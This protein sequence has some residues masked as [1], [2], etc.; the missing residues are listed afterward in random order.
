MTKKHKAIVTYS[1]GK[2]ERIKEFL[3]IYNAE[4]WA[5]RMIDD[6]SC[7]LGRLVNIAKVMIYPHNN[8]PYCYEKHYLHADKEAA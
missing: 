1:K 2:P 5:Q 4:R 3:S 8:E 7:A 6:D